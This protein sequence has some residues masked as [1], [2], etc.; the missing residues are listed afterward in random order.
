MPLNPF[1]SDK[2]IVESFTE[3]EKQFYEFYLETNKA[4]F[5]A[6]GR[7]KGGMWA[8]SDRIIAFWPDLEVRARYCR[9]QLDWSGRTND[10]LKRVIPQS[11]FFDTISTTDFGSVL[12]RG[13]HL[14][15]MEMLNTPFCLLGESDFGGVFTGYAM[16][17]GPAYLWP[18]FQDENDPDLVHQNILAINTN[19]PVEGEFIERQSTARSTPRRRRSEADISG[20]DTIR[21]VDSEDADGPGGF[22]FVQLGA[23]F[24]YSGTKPWTELQMSERKAIVHGPWNAT[25]FGVVLQI[26]SRGRPG[27]VW[28]ICNFHTSG[29]DDGSGQQ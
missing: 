21:S 22:I 19:V 27:P 13:Q 14:W 11:E 25:G 7:R 6:D 4:V 20:G 1:L 2:E 18:N 10:R 9:W 8:I 26:D 12:A 23:L 28:V 15:M 16:D 3:E 24:A 17:P 29:N 5:D